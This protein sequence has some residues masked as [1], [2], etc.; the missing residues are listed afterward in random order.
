MEARFPE[1][2]GPYPDEVLT[3]HCARVEERIRLSSNSER[4]LRGLNAKQVMQLT[5][6]VSDIDVA[7]KSHRYFQKSRA[8]VRKAV[9]EADRRA[10]KLHRKV[11]AI[12][13][14]LEDLRD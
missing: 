3:R 12:R 5:A 8:E 14:K 7:L 11:L 13:N 1:L 2:P 4:I 10:R 9:S 6:L